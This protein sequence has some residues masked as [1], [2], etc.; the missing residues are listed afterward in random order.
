MTRY[1]K[2]PLYSAVGICS[3][4]L[5]VAYAKRPGRPIFSRNTLFKTLNLLD[6]GR[7]AGKT[8]VKLFKIAGF[9]LKFS[10]L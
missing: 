1:K 8:Q 9:E 2:T 7:F 10:R 4:V 5:V 3:G 6:F